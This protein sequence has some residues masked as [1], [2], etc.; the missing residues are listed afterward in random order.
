ML[1]S[2]NGSSS[3][4]RLASRDTSGGPLDQQQSRACDT[5]LSSTIPIMTPVIL[6]T[7]RLVLRQFGPEDFAPFADLCADAEVMRYLGFGNTLSRE[8]SWRTLATMIGH[9]RLRGYGNWAVVERE[10]DTMIGRIGFWNPEGWPGFEL[11]WVI[12]RD[13]WGRGYAT[14]GAK[15]AL[16]HAF[17]TLGQSRVISLIRP[18]NIRSIRV[19]EKLGETYQETIE[20]FGQE[21][22]VYAITVDHWDQ[23]QKADPTR[24]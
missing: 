4:I 18:D 6:T 5:N 22:T 12:S 7:P 1:M 9:W 17:S 20:L 13:R 3:H 8:E 11:G 16:D 21:A 24:T 2:R 14:E 10:T 15:A 23:Q 19:A